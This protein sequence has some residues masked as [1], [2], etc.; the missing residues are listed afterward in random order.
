MKI[1][2][3]KLSEIKPYENNPRLNDDAV[4]S[5]AQSIREFG[6]RQSIVVD[7]EYVIIVGHT[8][9]KAAL[10][11]G[12]EKVPT[13]VAKD[14]T[15]E[16]IK[17]YRIADNKTAELSD[18]NYDLLPI[19]LAELRGM[20]YD[21]GLLGFDQDELATL[22]DPGVKD[23]LCDPDEVPAQ[24]DEATTRPGDLWLLGYHRLLCADCTETDSV[25]R[26]MNGATAGMMFT[27]PPWNV[28]IGQDGN[29]RHRQRP[30]LINDNLPADAF[31]ALL[32]GFVAAVQSYVNGD[33]YCILGASEWPTL[34]A[35]LRSHDYHWSATI[36]WVK[37]TFVLG[38]SKYHR[39]YEPI[40]YGWHA[41]CKSSFN[42]QRDLND[43]WEI[44][45]PKRSDEHPTMKPVALA[46]Q[47]IANSSR[48]G[49]I[50]LDPFAGS[51]TALIAAEQMGR[52][53]FL[54]EIDPTYC[55]VIV[56][57]FEKFTGKKAE[58]KA[59]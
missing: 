7:S 57:R 37:D 27:D 56:Q 9:Y 47:A 55:D 6:F 23:G 33:V 29:P 10:K 2:L 18:W 54:I 14:L 36:I 50:I 40:W 44:P 42:N 38:R 11:L 4:D 24:P 48:P 58:R 41:G 51:G 3:R 35:A 39:R 5:V 31:I 13:H 45:R 32:H 17:A 53:A 12:L 22:L 1:E 46:V 43:V 21:L 16:Q 8:R 26:L 49:S 20:N 15:P 52:K 59:S 34:D 25:A 30:G 28:A 19:E